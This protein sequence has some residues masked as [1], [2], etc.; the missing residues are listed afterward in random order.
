MSTPPR[1]VLLAL[2]DVILQLQPPLQCYIPDDLV[3]NMS[4]QTYRTNG[5]MLQLATL[6]RP[7][8]IPPPLKPVT[9]RCT[10]NTKSPK[11][12]KSV[13]YPRPSTRLSHLRASGAASHATVSTGH[14]AKKPQAHRPDASQRKRTRSPKVME[15]SIPSHSSL[16]WCT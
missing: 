4:F 2:A 10:H 15:D 14:L 9:R 12:T 16:C 6:L 5:Q 1:C 13:L 8:L 3:V 11:E 7:R